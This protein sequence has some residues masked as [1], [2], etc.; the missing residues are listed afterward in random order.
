MIL[1]KEY[2]NKLIDAK[3]KNLIKVIT[4]I[5]RSGKS[6]LMDQFKTYLL[7]NGVEEHQIIHLNFESLKY[8]NLKNYTALYAYIMDK[9]VDQARYYILLDEIQE[10]EGWEKTLSSL[11]VDL[12]CDLYI[13]GSNAKLLSSELATYISGRYVE[14]H[15]L[16]LSFKEYNSYPT[17]ET[18]QQNF[19]KFSTYGGF[20]GLVEIGNNEALARDYLIGIYNT[21]I[22]K[23][24]I[25]RNNF[26]D[27]ELIN[28][29]VKF[30]VDNIGNLMSAT[31]IADYLTSSG[32][33]THTSTVSEYLQALENA[34][35]IYKVDRYSIKGKQRLKAPYKYYVA[36][37]GLRGSAL[38]FREMD[39][40]RV[41]EN[42]VFLELIRRGYH[43]FVG[44]DQSFEVDFIAEKGQERIYYQVSLSVVDENVKRREVEALIKIP[45]NFPKLL[46]TMDYHAGET[47]SGI[48]LVNLLDF[49]LGI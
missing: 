33:K 40:G 13:T 17:D 24:V 14:I 34:F 15:M 23:D 4:G 6:V 20:P 31:K 21:I 49:L 38:G 28:L 7:S 18:T 27:V 46:L 36:D 3:D 8:E 42:V 45:D 39:L 48:K 25:S 37:L 16:P 47:I 11:Q 32:R 2:L 1:R 26:R 9:A 29:I 41:I 43:V 19:K 35:A 22:V 44:A 10:V 5:R 12:E 30:V